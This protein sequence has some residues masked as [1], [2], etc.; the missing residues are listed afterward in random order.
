[1][2]SNKLTILATLAMAA[3]QAQAEP[4]VGQKLRKLDDALERVQFSAEFCAEELAW[5]DRSDDRLAGK[6]DDV[7]IRNQKPVTCWAVNTA[8]ESMNDIHLHGTTW[9][10]KF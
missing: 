2:I 7:D 8:P 5:L 6:V 10:F 4:L 3:Q 1:M 9:W